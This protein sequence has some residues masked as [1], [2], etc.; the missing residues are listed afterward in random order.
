MAARD[1]ML[2]AVLLF[3]LGLGFFILN[4][5]VTTS[6]DH[7]TNTTAINESQQVV[8]AFD[9]AKVVVSKLDYL[10]LT[11]FIGLVLGLIISGWFIG[12]NPLFMFIYFIVVTMV[13]TLS[14]V[15]ANT[16]ESVTQASIFGTTIAAMPVTN[17]LLLNL[18]YYIAVIGIIGLIVMFAKPYFQENY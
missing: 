18:P 16:W 8:D 4:F 11:M 15:L 1:V 14:T 2:I 5:V 6:I 7:L 17:H 9:S 13:V 10:I 12:G 3:S